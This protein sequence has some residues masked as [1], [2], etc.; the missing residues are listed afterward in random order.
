MDIN[1]W[2]Q[3]YLCPLDELRNITVPMYLSISMVT[4]ILHVYLPTLNDFIVQKETYEN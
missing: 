2:E 4:I 1:R 3:H